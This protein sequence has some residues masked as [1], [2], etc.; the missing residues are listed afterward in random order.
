MFAGKQDPKSFLSLR[1]H[2]N[3]TCNMQWRGYEDYSLGCICSC[4]TNPLL[5]FLIH[6]ILKYVESVSTISDSIFFPSNNM[7]CSDCA[8]P[9]TSNVHKVYD[10]Y[11][12]H[13]THVRKNPNRI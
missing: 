1:H 13:I 3:M 10:R 6:I 4:K 9:W 8:R 5:T 7:Y 11:C 2:I 12:Q